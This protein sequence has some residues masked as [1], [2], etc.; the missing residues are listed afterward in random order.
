M[1]ERLLRVQIVSKTRSLW[2]GSAKQ[3]SI[4]AADGSLGILPG[5][6]PLLTILEAGTVRLTEPDGQLHEVEVEE[7][8]AFVDSDLVTLVTGEV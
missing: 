6:Q 5:R 4:P 3:V 2:D 7:G 1:S 8:F